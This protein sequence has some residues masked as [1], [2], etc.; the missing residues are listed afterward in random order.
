MY[1]NNQRE[2]TEKICQEEI[3]FLSTTHLIVLE[4]SYR[5]DTNLYGK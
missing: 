3:W 4:S 5:A 1:G 2:I